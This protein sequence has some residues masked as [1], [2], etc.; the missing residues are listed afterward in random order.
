MAKRRLTIGIIGLQPGRGWASRAHI[1]A[2][3][4]LSEICW[5]VA[6]LNV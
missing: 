5:G 4:A 2:L 3:H 6:R 1:P